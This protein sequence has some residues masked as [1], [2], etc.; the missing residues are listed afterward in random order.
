MAGDSVAETKPEE[1]TGELLVFDNE[2]EDSAK[3]LPATKKNISKLKKEQVPFSRIP[4]NQAIDAKFSSNKYV[5]YDYA[6][7]AYQDL[8]VT[9]GKGFTKEKNK[10]KR[11]TL[12]PIKQPEKAGW[13]RKLEKEYGWALSPSPG[14][15]DIGDVFNDNLLGF[16]ED[17]FAFMSGCGFNPM[18]G[19]FGGF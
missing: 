2:D 1:P 6:N 12:A 14:T 19:S 17:T 11:G 18:S 8:S 9:K 10:K 7:R 15:E 5:P 4:S 13:Q 3:R 16:K